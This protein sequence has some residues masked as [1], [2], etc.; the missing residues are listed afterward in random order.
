MS[1]EQLRAR[2]AGLL[3]LSA[4]EFTLG[5]WIARLSAEL[6]AGWTRVK[7]A[8]APNTLTAFAS[9]VSWVI[10]YY[11]LHQPNPVFA[12]IATFLCLGFS[13]N[14]EPRKVL[15]LGLGATFGVLIGEWF[16]G[17]FGFGWWQ[18]LV[19]MLVTPLMGRLI[20]GSD[21]LTF[22]L[23]IN[24]LVVGSMILGAGS[25]STPQT[26][27]LDALVG[28]L[29]AFLVSLVLPGNILTRPRRYAA[30]ALH[31]SAKVL[32]SLSHALASADLLPVRDAFSRLSVLRNELADGRNALDSA[33]QVASVNPA[34]TKDRATLAE[35][36]RLLQLAGRMQTSVFMLGRQ[37]R[38]ML[39]ETGAQ[40]EVAALCA[41]VSHAVRSI[42]DDVTR[43]RKPEEG[44]QLALRI[45]GKLA[46]LE[47]AARDDWRTAALISLMR[48]VAVDV[49]QL[50]GL[51]M[52]QARAALANADATKPR[53]SDVELM[54]QEK[55]SEV[56]GTSSF[57]S[58]QAKPGKADDS[59]EPEAD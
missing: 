51:S 50:T 5:H 21:L 34:F 19:L 2:V 28:A 22:Q 30:A 55:A 49:L 54:P 15:E 38:G 20:D 25:S 27:W 18:V 48:A 46:P 12:P 41:D 24:A 36:D 16:G 17:T 57:P 6:Q 13:R 26:R 29:V 42:A 58:Y 1:G 35:L 8:V 52:E 59:Q 47:L 14:R 33:M 43:W 3:G 11:L 9:A 10:C 32:L 53:A 4:E 44:R 45:A 7:G 56:W 31:E 37:T 23:A 39:T 40:P